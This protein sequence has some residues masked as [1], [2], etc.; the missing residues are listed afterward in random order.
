MPEL[1]RGG[2]YQLVKSSVVS[3]ELRVILK[4][5]GVLTPQAV[6]EVASDAASPLHGL[7]EWDDE[8]AA[9][10]Y[11][12]YQ[13]RQIIS[14]QKITINDREVKEFYN[15]QITEGARETAYFSVEQVLSNEELYNRA[16]GNAVSELETWREK[17]ESLRELK[18]VINPKP[19]KK[20]KKT[21]L[22]N[23][24]SV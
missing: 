9:V 8:V 21:L 17:Y 23:V 24:A 14:H 22:E 1:E 7:F 4:R 10:Q 12:V 13:A 11:R 16:L 15:L 2:E 6:V 5:D 19:L 20:V 18:G 3:Q